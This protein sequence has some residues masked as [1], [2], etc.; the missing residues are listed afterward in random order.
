VLTA[1][2]LVELLRSG[3]DPAV[4]LIHPSAFGLDDDDKE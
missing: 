4:P 3:W 2:S 1:P